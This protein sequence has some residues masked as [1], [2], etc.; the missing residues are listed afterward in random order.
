MLILAPDYENLQNFALATYQ[1]PLNMVQVWLQQACLVKSHFCS[2]TAKMQKH[3]NVID[4]LQTFHMFQASVVL[5]LPVSKPYRR[6]GCKNQQAKDG[7]CAKTAQKY[8]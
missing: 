5:W 1:K 6:K 3:E 2:S 7:C 8:F 4:F